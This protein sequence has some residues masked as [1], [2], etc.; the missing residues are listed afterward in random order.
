LEETSYNDMLK[1]IDALEASAKKAELVYIDMSEVKEG[2]EGVATESYREMLKTVEDIESRQKGS[3]VFKQTVKQA[4]QAQEVQKPVEAVK[5]PV[6]VAKK[7]MWA[8]RTVQP[9]KREREERE[10]IRAVAGKMPEAKP[11]FKG[12][13]I[14]PA[15]DKNLVLPG[16]QISDQV[17]ELER[18][19]SA[20]KEH[21]LDDDQI[22]VARMEIEGLKRNV[23]DLKREL[24]RDNMSLSQLEQTLW[25][26]RDQ[27]LG[28]AEELLMNYK[29]SG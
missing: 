21:L 19:V 17:H 14:K 29:R 1:V 12:I 18:I 27:R 3:Q 28:E 20:L 15:S 13:R 8:A 22:K 10:E 5:K 2:T 25:D 16:L 7:P 11:R 4:P 23:M 6:E 9:A 26:M 24:Q